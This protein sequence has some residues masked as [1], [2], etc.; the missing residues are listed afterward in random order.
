MLSRNTD[1]IEVEDIVELL[2]INGIT[3]SREELEA[4]LRRCDHEGN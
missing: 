3:A 2:R 1:N 4:I